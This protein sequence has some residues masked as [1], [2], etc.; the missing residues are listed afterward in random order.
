MH[1]Q[2]LPGGVEDHVDHVV[3]DSNHDTAV[4]QQASTPVTK[5]T[6]AKA[7]G[8]EEAPPVVIA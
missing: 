6:P 4:K 1:D 8:G 3:H 5:H 7:V 2:H